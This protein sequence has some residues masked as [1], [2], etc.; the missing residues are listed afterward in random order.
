MLLRSAKPFRATSCGA[1]GSGSSGVPVVV[2]G[3]GLILGTR[4]KGGK[5]E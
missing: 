5:K 4:L 2:S 3:S 1:G